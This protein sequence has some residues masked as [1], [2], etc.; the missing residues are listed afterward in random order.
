MSEA[1]TGRQYDRWLRRG[2]L[3]G[4]GYDF[5][6]SVPGSMIVNTPI[7][8]L[9]KNLTLK[10]ENRV[11]DIGCGRASL[12]QILSARLHFN[13]PPVGIDLSG[14]MLRRG[15]REAA[16][17][18]D[19]AQAAGTAMPF[20]DAVFDIVTCS[21]VLKHLDDEALAGFLG[22]IRR[23]LKPGA[24]AVLW[25]FAPTRSQR[26]NDWHRWLL[27]RGVASCNLRTYSQVAAAATSSGF[28]WVENA[29]LRPF[30]LPPIPRISIVAGKAP[31]AWRERTGPGRIRRAAVGAMSAGGPANPPAPDTAAVP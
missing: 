26:L 31:E 16:H 17:A 19:L 21:Y 15:R 1:D 9:D 7:F 30:L 5:I 12:L 2:S 6:A 3:S 8:R 27:T 28:E 13:Q 4:R 20:A 23:V 29:R 25:E 24:Y 18:I 10:P 11:L 22:E 14:E